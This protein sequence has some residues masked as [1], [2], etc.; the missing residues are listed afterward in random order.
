MAQKNTA[1]DEA[2]RPAASRPPRCAWVPDNDPLYQAYHDSEWG[3]PER[4]ARALYEL[5]MLESF[6]AG[7]SWKTILHKRVA[8]RAAFDGFDPAR[9]ADYG[10]DKIEAL[11]QDAG[12][13]RHR[14]KIVA[15]IKGAQSW[16]RLEREQAGGFATFIWDVVEGEPRCSRPATPADLPV[17]TSQAEQLSKKLKQAGFNFVGPTICYA[18]MQAAGLVDDHSQDCFCAH[19]PASPA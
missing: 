3:R 5:L 7:L 9:I 13:V 1:A 18:F 11:L 19:K 12:I 8:F 4:D 17:K 14:G 2:V 6:Q 15:T 16:L 10:E